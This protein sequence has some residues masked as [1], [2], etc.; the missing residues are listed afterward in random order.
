MRQPSTQTVYDLF[1]GRIQFIVPVYQRPYVW[2][3]EENWAPLWDDVSDIATR[4]LRDPGASTHDRHFLGPIV[5]EQQHYEPGGVD[6]RLVIDGQQ[7]LTTLQILLSAARDVTREFDA[8]AV[9]DDIASLTVNRGPSVTGDLE[10]K[11]R[12]SMR[13]R[14]AFLSAVRVGGPTSGQE[15]GLEAAYRYFARRIRSWLKS[16]EESDE[17]AETE[18]DLPSWSILEKADALRRCLNGLLYVVS[19][20]LDETDNAQVIFETL[21][22]RGT[23]LGALDLVKNAGF[24]K[25]QQQR[26][27][28]DALH[29]DYWL[30]TF[31][32]DSYWSQEER[33]GRQLRPRADWFLMHWMAVECEEVVRVDALFNKFRSKL[34]TSNASTG[35]LMRRLCED[36]Q[37]YRSF[38]SY[39]IG[40]PEQLFFSRMATMDT[41]TMLPIA[42]LLFRTNELDPVRRTRALAA[43]ESWLVRRAVLRLTGKNYNRQ[44]NALIKAIKADLAHA[45]D[46][47]IET[48]R[49]SKATTSV[50]PDDDQICDRLLNRTLYRYV[51][52]PRVRMLLEACE[53]A[54][55]QN[56]MT[57]AGP[58]PSDL[59][60]EHIMPQQSEEHW[61]LP[62]GEDEESARADRE[63]RVDRLG[64][65]TLVAHP[66]NSSMSNGPWTN[67]NGAGGKRGALTEHSVL[68]L[69][70]RLQSLDEWDEEAID[71]RG[72]ELTER[73]LQTWPGP[74]SW[75]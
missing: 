56:S 42:L 40:S 9:S 75:S 16:S 47:V 33:Q 66:L 57:E 10:L 44:L 32:T 15:E 58:V 38:I 34:L 54:L 48:L 37:T 51:G 73:I 49:S 35:D 5:L 65:L 29:R 67:S 74:S 59:S 62:S 12:P 61:P 50:W 43:L 45:D 27:P 11:I 46:A 18:A 20:N 1:N 4:Y 41:T 6:Q 71:R 69:N 39:P 36:A 55:R 60:I 19:I 14:G 25:V 21:N 53:I 52:Q 30:P 3:Q 64:N 72:Q 17:E 63:E 7:R 13:D 68:L 70:N 28:A 31:E 22:A 26:G 23:G 8:S 24:L 2:K